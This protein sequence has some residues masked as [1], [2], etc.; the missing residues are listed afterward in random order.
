MTCEMRR[1]GRGILVL[2]AIGIAG[3]TS[4]VSGRAGQQSSVVDLGQPTRSAPAAVVAAPALKASVTQA[5]SPEDAYYFQGELIALR[6]SPSEFVVRFV[7]ERTPAAN[8]TLVQGLVP[9][10]TVETEARTEGRAF[11]VVTMPIS[12]SS[13]ATVTLGAVQQNTVL[14]QLRA[15]SDTD[16]VAPV[17]YYPQTGVRMLPTDQII[18]KLRQ[19][20]TRQ[21]LAAVAA[22]LRL[23]I[24]EPMR[25]TTDE[26]V[27]RLTQ[28][29]ADDPL[30]RSRVLAQSNIVEWAEPDF[31]QEFQKQSTPNDSR[32]GSQWHLNNTGQ[33]GG[34]AGSD[35]KAG[36]AW[37]INAG[38]AGIVIAVI[39]DGVEQAHEDLAASIFTNPGEIPGNG[40]D[41][42]GNTYI[43]D[44]NGWDFSNND[45]NSNP[46]D[47][48]D[49][50]G[51]AVAGVAAAR[52]NNALGVTGACQQC[53][54][55]PVKIFSP[56]YAGDS[57]VANAIRYA[58]SFADVIN[59]S[60]GGGSPSAALQSAIQFAIT[61]GRGGKGSVVL[62]ATGNSGRSFSGFTFNGFPVSTVRFRFEYTKSATGSAG[63]DSAWL[64][65]VR[66]PGGELVNFESGLPAGWTTGGA[67]PWTVV[68]DV[69]HADEGGCFTHAAKAGTVADGQISFLEVVKTVPAGSM[70]SGFWV[71]SETNLDGLTIR[72]DVGN[73]GTYEGTSPVFSGVPVVA[74]PVSYPAAH[75]ESIAVGSSSNFDCRS[76]YSQYG[77]EVAFLAPSGAGPLNLRIET[78]DRTGAAGYNTTVGSLGNYTEA[79]G[80]SGFSGTSSATP[81]ASGVAGLILSHNPSLTRAQVLQIMQSSRR[82]KSV[83][84][85]TSP[86]ATT[87]TASAG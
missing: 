61:S 76:G 38:S 83:L 78:T 4:T 26:F 37:D 32:F 3:S 31:I 71:S 35:V 36:L 18:A 47:V 25:S 41:D 52:G 40:I 54:I 19:G 68:D 62:F 6:R 17:F 65:W 9:T 45:N 56:A 21:E 55:L 64:G 20:V 86:D 44:V 29:K 8:Q 11:H 87:A 15:S 43:D 59:N 60:W 74:L 16:F 46:M 57:A 73:N 67:A 28:P 7:A 72:V 51:T 77:P 84:K 5:G 10:A 23:T 85:T 58:A 75:P 82:T 70:L 53:R 2:L 69:T 24:H 1:F 30:E 33:G 48:A 27:L 79:A 42:D 66:F 22:S 14:E 34:I 81:L 80:V 50:H 12:D 49:N 39:D 63:E 13:G